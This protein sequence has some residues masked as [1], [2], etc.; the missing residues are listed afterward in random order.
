[1]ADTYMVVFVATAVIVIVVFAIVVS[2]VFAAINAT[3]AAIVFRIILITVSVT[4]F[5]ITIVGPLVPWACSC[6]GAVTAVAVIIAIAIIAIIIVAGARVG[7]N[8]AFNFVT[9]AAVVPKSPYYKFL[10]ETSN[11]IIR[12]IGRSSKR[13]FGVNNVAFVMMQEK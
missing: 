7:I 4:T 1:M 12:Q 3:I 5:V 9:A 8:I 6:F 13:E 11:V 2:A 10:G